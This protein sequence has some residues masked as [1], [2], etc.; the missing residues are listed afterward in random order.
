MPRRTTTPPSHD[1][2]R[3]THSHPYGPQ[4]KR[5]TIV[6]ITPSDS[7]SARSKMMMCHRI[8][9]P[10]AILILR[11]GS[12]RS[13][14]FSVH[15][16][17]RAVTSYWMN[18]SRLGWRRTRKEPT[19]YSCRTMLWRGSPWGSFM[20]RFISSFD[21]K[22]FYLY[23]YIYIYIHTRRYERRPDRLFGWQDKFQV[24]LCDQ[25]CIYIYIFFVKISV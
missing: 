9:I 16:I 11:R 14:C 22:T 19:W 1:P 13:V 10:I 12:R 17:G 25:V 6:S 23:I 4:R 3:L 7:F 20:V 24:T 8:P 21:M 5:Q 18:S 2:S 15:I